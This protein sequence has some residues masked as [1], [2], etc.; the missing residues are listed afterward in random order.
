VQ[1]RN[2]T[3]TTQRDRGH[4]VLSHGSPKPEMFAYIHVGVS[5][6]GLES[7]S[8]PSIVCSD[9]PPGDGASLPLYVDEGLQQGR[10]CLQCLNNTSVE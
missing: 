6:P 9:S 7:I 5:Q 10:G 3:T 1:I 8:T 2:Q 4:R